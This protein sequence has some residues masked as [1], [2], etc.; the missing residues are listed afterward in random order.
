MKENIL[1]GLAM[2]LLAALAILVLALMGSTLCHV[3]A[4]A[5]RGDW[6][7]VWWFGGMAIC[8]FAFAWAGPQLRRR[9]KRGGR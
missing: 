9:R 4:D 7:G 6:F 3:V 8:W 2:L 1:D 5:R